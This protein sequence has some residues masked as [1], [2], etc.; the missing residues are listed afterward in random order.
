MIF[1][2][3]DVLTDINWDRLYMTILKR[4]TSIGTQREVG[5]LLEAYKCY[6]RQFDYLHEN[7]HRV[8]Q[9]YWLFYPGFIQ[10][11]QAGLQVKRVTLY[12]MKGRFVDHE[13]LAVIILRACQ[14]HRVQCF[15]R[16]FNFEDLLNLSGPKVLQHLNHCYGNYCVNLETS[17]NEK[18][19]FVAIFVKYMESYLRCKNA[20]RDGDFAILEVESVRWLPF[21]RARKRSKYYDACM[22]KIE[23]L[24]GKDMESSVLESMR[25]NRLPKLNADRSHVTHDE[26]N[27]LQNL[28]LKMLNPNSNF[29]TVV[30][31]STHLSI[32]RRCGIDVY[33]P[34][35]KRGTPPSEE[36]M[37]D[38]CVSVLKNAGVNDF[39]PCKLDKNFIWR[40]VAIDK[41]SPKAAAKG[42]NKKNKGQVKMSETETLYGE[43][44]ANLITAPE[45]D[46]PEDEDESDNEYEV[47]LQGMEIDG[48]EDGLPT[49][50]LETEADQKTALQ[51]LSNVKHYKLRSEALVDMFLKGLEG[52]KDVVRERKELLGKRKREEDK[53]RKA[54]AYFNER[55]RAEGE[56]MDARIAE[57]N[58]FVES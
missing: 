40:H 33:G 9:I 51:K 45:V 14:R 55:R 48:E 28:W 20:I 15:I 22:R 47:D 21:W 16:D 57:D 26:L 24:Y 5:V 4:L 6:I 36:S 23:T 49:T 17:S 13:K 34:S 18:S 46:A 31:Q 41:F 37:I 56:K 39:K 19:K 44:F 50:P 2:Y 27:E 35:A 3:G 8:D 25:I 54:V 32:Y 58:S 53:I 1:Q 29:D 30:S 10:G 52:E 42:K 43:L 12:P 11:F 38:Y 7:F